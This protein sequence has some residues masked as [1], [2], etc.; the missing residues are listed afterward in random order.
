M[1]AMRVSC[2]YTTKL[3]SQINASVLTTYI[4]DGLRNQYKMSVT[5]VGM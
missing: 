5:F 2:F 4:P 3:P 1:K